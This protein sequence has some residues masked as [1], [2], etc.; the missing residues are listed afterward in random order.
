MPI[1][2]LEAPES[3]WGDYGDIAVQGM[4]AHLGRDSG[5]V[6]QLERSGTFVP[7]ITFPGIS[8]I[9]VTDEFK[10]RLE[11]A[12]FARLAFRA[13]AKVHIVR[14]DWRTWDPEADPADMPESGEPEDLI[15]ARPHD[16]TLARAMG[17]LW[18]V[19][20]PVDASVE[21]V[22]RAQ[23]GGNVEIVLR[24]ASWT[25]ADLF[26][27]EGVGLIYAS[28]RAQSWLAS[29]VAEWIAFRDCL[30]A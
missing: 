4:S 14:L 10:R 30:I 12:D 3:P 29:E 23:D 16:E 1:K 11:S 6:L 19:V 20:L 18:D 21:R 22:R 27:A 13:V 28:E 5:G 9:V 7:P 8:D 2:I 26:R 17:V 25:G 24:L 15:L